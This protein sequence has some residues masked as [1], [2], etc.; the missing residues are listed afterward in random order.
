[1]KQ[2]PNDQFFSWIETEIAT[3]HS[4]QFR[5]KGYSMFPLLRNKQ[6][7]VILYP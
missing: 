7:K 6:D 5:L 3:G 1:M 4:V 2:I